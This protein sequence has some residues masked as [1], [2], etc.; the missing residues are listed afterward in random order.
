MSIAVSDEGVKKIVKKFL[1]GETIN[2]Y[3]SSTEYN[4][5]SRYINGNTNIDSDS[6][7]ITHAQL[8]RVLL[9]LDIRL[10]V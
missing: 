2:K 1:K 7:G 9:S 10:S 6:D 3:I 8:M 5:L 4:R